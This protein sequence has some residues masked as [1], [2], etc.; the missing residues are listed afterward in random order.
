METLSG[1]VKITLK[2]EIQKGE[3]IERKSKTVKIEQNG[4][5]RETGTEVLWKVVKKK[6]Y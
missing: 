3:Y 2:F 4:N 5:K 6:E 1:R